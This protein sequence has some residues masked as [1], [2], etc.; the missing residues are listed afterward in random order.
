MLSEQFQSGAVYIFD[1]AEF[2]AALCG[3]PNERNSLERISLNLGIQDVNYLHNAGNDAHVSIP[4][5]QKGCTHLPFGVVHVG[6]YDLDG[7]RR[8]CGYTEGEEMA[9]LRDAKGIQTRKGRYRLQQQ[10]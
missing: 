5:D 4:L 6:L 10:R 7:Q 1:T 9:P 8:T 3:F 2:F